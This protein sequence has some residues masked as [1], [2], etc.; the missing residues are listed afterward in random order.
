M[1]GTCASHRPFVLVALLLLAL[2]GCNG[3]PPPPQPGTVLDEASM[4]GRSR[5]SL[6]PQPDKETIAY[7]RDMDRGIEL[8]D[9]EALGRI[10]WN[11]GTG[12]ND[13]F[14]D[15]LSRSSFGTLDFLKTISSHPSLKNN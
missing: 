2:A 4:A 8:T 13:R 15:D 10:T 7:M 12:G 11:V 14:W 9:D 1:H 6:V 5:D 3:K